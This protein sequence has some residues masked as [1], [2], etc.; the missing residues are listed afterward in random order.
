MRF[1][2]NYFVAHVVVPS[3]LVFV[4]IVGVVG[5]LLGL[6]LIARNES[7]LRLLDRLNHWT[8]I[9]PA[10]RPLEIPHDVEQGARRHP[11]GLGVAVLIGALFS[12]Y[13]L[14]LRVGAADLTAVLTT[15]GSMAPLLWFANSIRWAL[16]AANVIALAIG[17]VLAFFPQMLEPLAAHANRWISARRLARKADA[18]DLTID[19][20]VRAYPR[21]AGTLIALGALVPAI[22]ATMMLLG[23]R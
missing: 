22:G 23:G 5:V 4:L 2:N 7:A 3:V 17:V 14:L 18:M 16:I 15:S 19:N 12:L 9:R 8:S 13:F 1:W 20:V 10:L 11:R 6:A 21:I